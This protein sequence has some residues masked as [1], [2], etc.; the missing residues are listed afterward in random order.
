MRK[1]ISAK[2]LLGIGMFVLLA[3]TISCPKKTAPPPNVMILLIDSLRADHLADYGYH[4]NTNPFLARFG[5]R[6]IRFTNAFT[7]STHT[8]V[9]VSSLFTGL[10]PV[11]HKVRKAA[12]P[13]LE[14][15]NKILSDILSDKFLT[16][17]EAF[18]NNRYTTGAF[19][20][21]P[22]LREFFG[23]DQGFDHYQ[24]LDS[25]TRADELNRAVLE[26][27]DQH[28][29]KP[30]FVY[31]HYMDVHMPYNPPAS[32]QG[33]YFFGPPR[34]L[35]IYQFN[36][37]WR[38]AQ[39]PDRLSLEYT[40]ALYDA[41]INYWDDAFKRFISALEMRGWLKN[42]LLIILA[43]HGEEFY[44]HR[45]F[46]HGFTLYEEQLHIPLY[47]I[48]PGV[49]KENQTNDHLVQT[50]DLFPTICHLAKIKCPNLPGENIFSPQRKSKYIYSETY[51]GKV[52][53]SIRTEGYKLVFNAGVQEYEM[54]N[55]VKLLKNLNSP[56]VKNYLE[57]YDLNKD[58]KER[59]NIFSPT[60]PRVK[61]YIYQLLQVFR[62]SRGKAE[63]VEL[64]Q[65]T[66]K[67]LKSLGYIK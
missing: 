58:P 21:N 43:D 6:G 47:I 10:L 32:Y 24:Y 48:F 16:M 35:Y 63:Q 23:L 62:Q 26:W 59:N 41:Q 66:I 20:T 50:I 31:V 19:V 14:N 3:L 18:K 44:D 9:V 56:L 51:R 46:G 65:R 15:E 13:S 60:N 22:H 27:L 42:T 57:L 39:E 52:P 2:V 38:F 54:E 29:E 67:E 53:R 45:G 36:G 12:S 49:L 61:E 37:P 11:V 34:G 30:V 17:A 64:D 33:L 1:K 55:L 25:L 5:R 28:Q 8:K 7:Q 40:V 4:R